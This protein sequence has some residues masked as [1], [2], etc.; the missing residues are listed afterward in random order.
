V[1]ALVEPT[2]AT[3]NQN[4]NLEIVNTNPTGQA[5]GGVLARVRFRESKTAREALSF[6]IALGCGEMWT[7]VVKQQPNGTPALQSN[8]PVVTAVGNT[9]STAPS[10]DPERGGALAP[11]VVPAGTVPADVQRGY[12]EVIAEE[13]LPCAPVEAGGPSVGGNTY[14]RL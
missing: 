1:R 3:G 5:E 11:F 14:S 2:G 4:S 8:H 10:F 6:E 9:V 7:G 12:L 13:T